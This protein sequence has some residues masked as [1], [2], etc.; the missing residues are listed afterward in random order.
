[1]TDK[2]DA[3]R[4]ANSKASSGTLLVFTLSNTTQMASSEHGRSCAIIG[5]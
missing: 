5:T 2:R 3:H 1:M 4:M